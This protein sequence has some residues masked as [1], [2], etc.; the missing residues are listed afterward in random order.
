MNRIARTA[1]SFILS[2]LCILCILFELPH[3]G[4]AS[5]KTH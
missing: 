2:I 4:E 3:L 1:V 5:Q